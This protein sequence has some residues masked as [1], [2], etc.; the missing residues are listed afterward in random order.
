[1]SGSLRITTYA[2]FKR[3]V[4]SLNASGDLFILPPIDVWIVW[5]AY[6]LNPM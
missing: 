6:M 5:H 4:A 2:R 3:W 1:M